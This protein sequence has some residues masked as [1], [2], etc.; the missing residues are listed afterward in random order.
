LNSAAATTLEANL[1]PANHLTLALRI[2]TVG[3]RRGARLEQT[4]NQPAGEVKAGGMCYHLKSISYFF[5]V[6]NPERKWRRV[7]ILYFGKKISPIDS[8]EHALTG[9]V[10]AAA[11]LLHSPD[12][13]PPGFFPAR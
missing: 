5:K 8:F 1:R 12:T 9:F 4:E 13:F 11:F 2:S 10:L 3:S 6:A 7:D